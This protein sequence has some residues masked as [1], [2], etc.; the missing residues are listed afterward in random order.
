MK[1]DE[2]YAESFRIIEAE[3]GEHGFA[4]PEWRVVR[5]MIHASG[6]LEL[7]RMVRF[8]HDAVASGIRALREGR[9]IVT[10]VTMVA[11]GL[12]REQLGRLK[13]PIA[14]F[15]NDDEVR[16]QAH[17]RGETRSY[18]A[19]DKAC[20]ELPEAIYVI[21][22]APTALF[23]L[24]SAVQVGRCRPRLILA[25][26]V[27]FVSVVESKAEALTLD[28]PLIKISGR[29]GGSAVA[30]AAMNALAELALEGGPA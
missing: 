20:R 14:C 17:S 11:A 3:V 21:G 23:A 19:M 22:N 5:R 8:G 26:P 27:G 15:I 13:V 25:M 7:A 29:K 16:D 28:V 12:N 1:P 30:A 9:P 18:W 4:P 2:I 6:D 10:D 24:C